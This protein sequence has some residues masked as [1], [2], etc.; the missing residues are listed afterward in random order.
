MSDEKTIIEKVS[1][2]RKKEKEKEKEK[3]ELLD[4]IKKWEKDGWEVAHL[5]N[6][7]EDDLEKGN[8]LI[9]E[10]KKRIKRLEKINE[11]YESLK[12]RLP[13]NKFN[14][15][16]S[17]LESDLKNPDEVE[18]LEKRVPK[19]EKR[20]NKIKKKKREKRREKK[21]RKKLMEKVTKWKNE[22]FN[23]DKLVNLLK[24][25]F[26]EGK[27]AFEEY[28][29]NID[30][31]KLLR[32]KYQSLGIREQ[33]PETVEI[34]HK[35]N[36]PTAIGELKEKIEKLEE[37]ER[38]TQPGLGVS[39][40]TTQLASQEERSASA[41]QA[42]EV[43]TLDSKEDWQEILEDLRRNEGTFKQI[44]DLLKN[45][46]ELEDELVDHFQTDPG[47]RED[48][49]HYIDYWNM[50]ISQEEDA[51]YFKILETDTEYKV[52]KIYPNSPF[53][54]CLYGVA[55]LL[56]EDKIGISKSTHPHLYFGEYLDKLYGEKSEE[57]KNEEEDNNEIYYF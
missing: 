46:E 18:K 16:T 52:I 4:K 48:F 36:D 56:E 12:Q 17:D 21:K 50:N 26:E 6:K 22:G 19:L 44:R 55:S 8:K 30:E 31:L 29:E 9:E 13:L 53:L 10:Y 35:L 23:V 15:N 57:L 41:Q 37:R 51:K 49:L 43:L 2:R 47:L 24:E 7:V 39:Q 42:P 3:Q 27:E 14:I 33:T 11:R 5:K 45:K 28:E 1:E 20:I 38:L 34:E 25:D 32:K 40:S 54:A